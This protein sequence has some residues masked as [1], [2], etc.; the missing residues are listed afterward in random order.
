MRQRV[1]Q[2]QRWAEIREQA[3]VL[4]EYAYMNNGWSGPF[5]TPVVETMRR[6]GG[7]RGSQSFS[8]A[9]QAFPHR[10]VL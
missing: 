5:S 2:E 10:E 6:R 3:P 4:R 9:K 8:R 7:Q 1:T